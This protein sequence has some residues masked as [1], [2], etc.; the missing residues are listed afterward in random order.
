MYLPDRVTSFSITALSNAS[1]FDFES[2][3]L[4][5]T[6]SMSSTSLTGVVSATASARSVS[7][8]TICRWHEPMGGSDPRHK[9]T[10]QSRLLLGELVEVSI[11]SNL[12]PCRITFEKI[13]VKVHRMRRSSEYPWRMQCRKPASMLELSILEMP[14]MA[15]SRT[16]PCSLVGA[17]ED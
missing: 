12:A 16:R 17:F 9:R 4:I 7:P 13:R 5:T 10:S 15:S 8:R 14:V 1:R 6:G 3:M 2:K 11:P